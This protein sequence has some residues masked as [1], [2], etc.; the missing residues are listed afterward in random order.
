MPRTAAEYPMASIANGIP[1]RAQSVKHA[2]TGVRQK[3]RGMLADVRVSTGG[4]MGWKTPPDPEA[5]NL[6]R[7]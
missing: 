5:I 7:P 3:P 4:G 1:V 6:K 2:A